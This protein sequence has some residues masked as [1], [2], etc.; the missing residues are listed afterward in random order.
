MRSLF[1][2]TCIENNKS[3]SNIMPKRKQYCTEPGC[4]GNRKYG[5]LSDKIKLRCKDHKGDMIDLTRKRCIELNCGGLASYG[6]HF[7]GARYCPTHGKEKNLTDVSHGKCKE[8]GCP[9]RGH[10]KFLDADTPGTYCPDHKINGMVIPETRKCK[11]CPKRPSYGYA[12]ENAIVCKD[13]I[14][15]NMV[16]IIKG[17]MCAEDHCETRPSKCCLDDNK[18]YCIKHSQGK[19]CDPL[20]TRICETSGCGKRSIFGHPGKKSRFCVVHKLFDMEDLDHPKCINYGCVNRAS[21]KPD[22]YEKNSFCVD[23]APEG[24]I[25]KN[26]NPKCEECELSATYGHKGDSNA[27]RCSKHHLEGMVDV[28][29]K[30]C[31]TCGVK[32][33]VFALPGHKPRFCGNCRNAYMINVTKNNCFMGG[34][35]KR[36]F[37]GNPG[38]SP[39]SCGEHHSQGMISYPLRKCHECDSPAIYGLQCPTHCEEHCDREN[40]INLVHKECTVCEIIDVVDNQSRCA[41]CSDYLNRDLHRIKERDVKAILEHSDLPA[42]Q[43]YDKQV[44]NGYCGPERPD[45]VWETGTHVVILEVDENQHKHIPRDCEEIRMKNVTS[46][47]GGTPVFWIRYNPD[48]FK[49][50]NTWV[51]L[52]PL[53]RADILLQVIWR[54]LFTAPKDTSELC[55]VMY[56]FYDGQPFGYNFPMSTLQI[57]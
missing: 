8:K 48:S 50:K 16:L 24:S 35:T 10:Y 37:Y 21:V 36:A 13:H 25:R 18:K 4:N 17:S 20:D 3:F 7:K 15:D 54:A 23:H 49:E 28:V 1:Q 57:V 2:N 22:G 38:Q 42:F 46:T 52:T 34:C 14:R 43:Q 5:K 12:M 26:Y 40:H 27:I 47:F 41:R 29:H 39:I 51:R 53:K 30:M 6:E 19:R 31:E 11:D 56:L 9:E 45:F 44:D 33:P 32:N 55:R